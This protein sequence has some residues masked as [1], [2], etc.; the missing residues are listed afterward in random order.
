MGRAAFFPG[1]RAE[2][3][4]VVASWLVAG[5]GSRFDSAGG[6]NTTPTVT[7]AVVAVDPSTKHQT[8]DGFGAADTWAPNALTPAQVTAFFDPVNGIGLSL[9]RVGIDVN[10][11]PLGQGVYSDAIGAHAFGVKVWGAPW[12]PP[13]ADKS[14]DSLENGGTLNTSDYQSWASILAGFASTF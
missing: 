3:A 9:L 10:G 6:S 2:R 11:T 7:Q 1:W 5:C 13:P 12:S 14:N 8:M 4:V